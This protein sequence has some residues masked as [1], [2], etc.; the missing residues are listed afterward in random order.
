MIKFPYQTWS[1]KINDK[2]DQKDW[3]AEKVEQ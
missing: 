2:I 1:T 3:V